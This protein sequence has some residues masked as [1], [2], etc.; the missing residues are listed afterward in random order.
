MN[1]KEIHN[2]FE[3]E[4]NDLVDNCPHCWWRTHIKSLW[5]G[6]HELRS[7]NIEYYIIFR[8]V[9][10][11]K[12]LLKKYLVRNNTFHREYYDLEWWIDKYP[13]IIDNK[14]SHDDSSHIPKDI[15]EDYLEAI[16]CKSIWAYKASC[17]MFRRTLQNSLVQLW[18]DQTLD[19][20]VQ[21]NSLQL[22]SDIKD[23]AHQIR[24][25][26]NW[27]A[28]PDKDWL[29]EVDE[30]ITNEVHNFISEFLNYLFVMPK[31]V[32]SARTRRE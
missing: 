23:W 7:G 12:L 31:R 22:T 4:V 21:I 24:I 6:F 18:A 13:Q 16:A 2:F 27:W 1:I 9:P 30:E 25:F 17:S 32:E 20:V 29:K 19:L 10:C 15:L 5:K 8:C 11:E 3:N 26:W 28:H 14:F